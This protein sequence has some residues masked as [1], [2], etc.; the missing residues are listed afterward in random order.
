MTAY[1]DVLS[2]AKSMPWWQQKAL[3][4]IIAGETIGEHD[5]EEI[6]RSLFEE[7]ESPP[8]GGWLRSPCPR[9]Q[10]RMNRFV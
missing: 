2:W 4:R 7:P 9:R 8:E 6:A 3:A 5:Y 10:Q 1:E